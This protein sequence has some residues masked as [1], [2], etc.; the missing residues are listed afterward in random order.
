M[1]SKLL[2]EFRAGG[3]HV[4]VGEDWTCV[5]LPD[6]QE[7]HGAPFPEQAEFPLAKIYHGNL[8]AMCRQHDPLHAL[9]CAWI[10][11]PSHSLQQ[12]AGL[13]ADPELA[14]YE[15]EAVI[16]VQALLRAHCAPLPRP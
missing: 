14:A 2:S 3:M 12:A 9:L 4:T 13:P 16:A 6:G 1:R 5:R 8:N 7:I 15:E 10:G 11:V